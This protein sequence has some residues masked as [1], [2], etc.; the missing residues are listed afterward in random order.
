MSEEAECEK[1]ALAPA[2][3][4]PK[5]KSVS[6]KK[7]SCIRKSKIEDQVSPQTSGQQRGR[8]MPCWMGCAPYRHVLLMQILFIQRY[9]ISISVRI[10]QNNLPTSSVF[11]LMALLD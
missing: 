5:S 9:Q 8:A 7:R 3:K 1:P 4:I 10:V 2:S 6:S 11:H